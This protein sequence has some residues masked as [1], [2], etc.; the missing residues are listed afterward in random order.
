[1]Q[2][3][4]GDAVSLS[5]D[6]PPKMDRT[7]SIRSN[8]HHSAATTH[9]WASA[10]PPRSPGEAT[11]SASRR[12]RARRFARALAVAIPAVLVGCSLNLDETDSSSA[13]VASACL[14]TLACEA[15]VFAA[16]ATRGWRHSFTSRLVSHSGFANHRGRDLFVNPGAPQTVIAKLAYGIVDKDLEDEEVDIFVQRDCGSGW[17][18]LG[19]AISTGEGAGPSVEGVPPGGGRVFFEI[20]RDKQLGPGRHRLRVVVAGDGT[21]ADLFIDVV[22]RNT[23]IFVADVDGTLTSSENIEF[24]KLLTGDLPDTHAGAPEALRALAD[25]GYRPMYLSARPE[26]LVQRTRD[27]L[28]KHGFPP[29]IV[30]TTTTLTGGLGSAAAEF[31]RSEI[32]MLASK[33]LFPTYGFG[34][35]TSDSQ[36]YETIQPPDHR[37]F[38]QISGDYTGRKIN[39]YGELYPEFVGLAPACIR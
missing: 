1:M 16:P 18:K 31:K 25:K 21:S 27:F 14:P 20:P 22:P 32:A 8:V 38:F 3:A 11:S 34:N 2:E 28:A 13:A 33:G 4:P 30:Q 35:K 26:F 15:P 19:T 24:V 12:A 39:S 36:G 6:K 7:H 9:E 29:G 10:D 37:I 5:K 17:E 23:P